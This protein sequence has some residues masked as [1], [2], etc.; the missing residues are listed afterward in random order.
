MEK[1]LDWHI[2]FCI[3]AD[4]KATITACTDVDNNPYNMVEFYASPRDVLCNME[5]ETIIAYLEELGY[6]VTKKQDN[7]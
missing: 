4:R 1:S 6:K 2:N 7:G 3:A 5:A